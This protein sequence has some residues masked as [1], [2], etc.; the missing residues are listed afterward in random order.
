MWRRRPWLSTT[1]ERERKME[2][3]P[4]RPGRG[5][6][7]EPSGM[8][9]LLVFVLAEKE[10]EQV[11]WISRIDPLSTLLAGSLPARPP[12]SRV[13]HYFWIHDLFFH[14][15]CFYEYPTPPNNA[16]K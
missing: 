8:E 12:I 9:S 1:K 4:G 10:K 16:R 6:S 2:I 7:S 11:S 14:L 5:R 13:F 3:K 15:L